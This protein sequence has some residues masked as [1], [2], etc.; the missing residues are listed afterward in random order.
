MIEIVKDNNWEISRQFRHP[1][2]SDLDHEPSLENDNLYA[3]KILYYKKIDDFYIR[4]KIY[5]DGIEYFAIIETALLSA[6]SKK[7]E[8][9]ESIPIYSKKFSLA[10][11]SEPVELSMTLVYEIEKR[12][13]HKI[14]KV[15]LSFFIKGSFSRNGW[16][17]PPD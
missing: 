11:I 14:E 15:T 8:P 6:V 5:S 10:A 7:F 2:P 12:V 4:E 9:W 13:L 16:R 3:S 17:L 1:E